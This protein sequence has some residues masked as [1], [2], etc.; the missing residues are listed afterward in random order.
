MQTVPA[1]S[2]K[3]DGAPDF[4]TGSSGAIKEAF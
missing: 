4:T 2:D 3:T 1:A